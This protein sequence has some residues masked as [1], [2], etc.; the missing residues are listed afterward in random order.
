MLEK[1]NYFRSMAVLQQTSA[2]KQLK[3]KNIEA[4][5]YQGR[6]FIQINLSKTFKCSIWICLL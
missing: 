2:K 5:I 1:Q 6:P 3:L 4:K